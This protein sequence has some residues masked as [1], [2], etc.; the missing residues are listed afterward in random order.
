MSR[1]YIPE[2]LREAVAKRANYLCEYCKIDERF[3][4]LRFHL[5]HIFNEAKGGETSFNNL[6]YACAVCNHNKHS[7]LAGYLS[8]LK[9]AFLFFH[10]RTDDWDAFF[11]LRKDGVIDGLTNPAKAT[12][13]AL[14]M[15]RDQAVKERLFLL[16]MRTI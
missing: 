7:D 2:A 9:Q 11:V 15:N 6:A 10:P 16:E 5:D 8:E 14:D 1:T 12:I 4:G 3:T 13:R